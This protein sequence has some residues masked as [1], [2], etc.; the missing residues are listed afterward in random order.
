MATSKSAR[1]SA[2]KVQA[3]LFLL[4]TSYGIMAAWSQVGDLERLIRARALVATDVIIDWVEKHGLLEKVARMSPLEAEN[5][6]RKAISGA[7][8]V[9]MERATDV[10]FRVV[11]S[12]ET[13]GGVVGALLNM[14]GGVNKEGVQLVLTCEY[15]DGSKWLSAVTI[16]WTAMER[17]EVQ[18]QLRGQALDLG[19]TPGLKDPVRVIYASIEHEVLARRVAFPETGLQM[20]SQG[21][22]WLAALL[23]YV[24]LVQLWNLLEGFVTVPSEGDEPWV[25]LEG[26]QGSAAWLARM[27]MMSFVILPLILDLQLMRMLVLGLRAD[28]LVVH[29]VTLGVRAIAATLIMIGSCRC[30]LKV[31]LGLATIRQGAGSVLTAGWATGVGHET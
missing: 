7:A 26:R 9:R 27:W 8:S 13:I 1:I 24:L 20:T 5:E 4:V 16:D 12:Y 2:T 18:R 21:A 30:G 17:E 28:G 22:V 14:L 31:C 11:G 19:L 25:V 6:L 23:T 29:Q 3:T 15:E 10:R